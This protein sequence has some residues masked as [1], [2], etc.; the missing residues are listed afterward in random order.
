MKKWA[1]LLSGILI[2]AL[3]VTSGDEV[4][5]QVKSLV[6]QKVTGEYKIIV[7]GEVLQDKGA[8]IDGRTNA[9]VR[10]ISESLGADLKVDNKKKTITITTEDNASDNNSSVIGATDESFLII[11]QT[12]L[13]D[14]KKEIET[15]ITR[16]QGEITYTEKQLSNAA[17]GLETQVFEQA[18][19]Q[20]NS[21]IS[22][23]KS[24][25]A[26]INQKLLDV[27]AKLAALNK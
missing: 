13:Q 7:N 17:P 1:Y 15:E 25:L 11:E 3:V 14:Y 10:A 24:K 16:L 8:V 5:A 22:N 4:A 6:G 18:L 19:E 20:I 23:Q 26:E 21:N 27:N 9:P 2:G 12:Y